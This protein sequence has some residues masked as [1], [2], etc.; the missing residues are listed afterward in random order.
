M[1]YLLTLIVLILI[2]LQSFANPGDTIK[3]TPKIKASYYHNKFHGR[4]TTSGE[5]FNLNLLTCASRTYKLG[6]LL[7][8]TNPKT[9]KSVVVKVNDRGPRTNNHIDLSPA[10]FKKIADLG[11]GI[12]NVH[13]E[14]FD[15]L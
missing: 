12:I 9:K 11:A 1:K 2:K 13:I 7:E 15:E 3:A 10:A 14:V 4:L 8:V 6:T 5:R